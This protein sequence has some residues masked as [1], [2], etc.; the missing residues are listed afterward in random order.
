MPQSVA[1]EKNPVKLSGSVQGK[2]SL[3]ALAASA[4]GVQML[5][6][7]PT[8]EAEIVYTGAHQAIG[9][10]ETY[11]FDVNHDGRRDFTIINEF[12]RGSCYEGFRLMVTPDAGG[13]VACHASSRQELVTLFKK[14]DAI[15]KGEGFWPLRASMA[16]RF[17][18]CGGTFSYGAWFNVVDGYL[19]F[20]FNIDGQLHYGWARFNVINKGKFRTVALLTGYAYETDPDTPI[21]AG[22]TGGAADEEGSREPMIGIPQ[23]QAQ[24][25]AMLGALALGAPGL[26]L[27]RRE[28]S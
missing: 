13:A 24:P 15:E 18:L 23:P 16:V 2:L 21:I 22:D 26:E 4:V 6:L 9:R 8:T 12:G 11:S 19:G 14:G 1:R 17:D 7:T 3:Y 28:N 25:A 27:W 10:N 5:A 20:N